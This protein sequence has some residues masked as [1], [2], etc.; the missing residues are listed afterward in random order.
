MYAQKI[1]YWMV[2]LFIYMMNLTKNKDDLK[3]ISIFYFLLSLF[4]TFIFLTLIV[5]WKQKKYMNSTAVKEKYERQL[6]LINSDASVHLEINT[7]EFKDVSAV[8]MFQTTPLV[9]KIVQK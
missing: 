6:L 5:F 8:E 9:T 1:L 3:I 4:C 7:D 2:L